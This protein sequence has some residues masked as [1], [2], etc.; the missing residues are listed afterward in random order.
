VVRSHRRKIVGTERLAVG[1]GIR[2]FAVPID[3]DA[4]LCLKRIRQ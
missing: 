4:V 1:D 3:G 2:A